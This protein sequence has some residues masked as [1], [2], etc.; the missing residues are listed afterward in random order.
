MTFQQRY[1]SHR[2]LVESWLSR[3]FS[4]RGFPFDGLLEAIEYS[5]LAGGKR[6]RPVLALEFCRVC[7]GDF[8]AALPIA[9][10]VELLHTYSLI[11]DD[12]PC[13]DDD[14]L[15]RG[16]PTNHKV[17]GECTAVLAGD[18][19]QAEA[20]ASIF[21][22]TLP[23]ERQAEC[24]RILAGAA[25][26][27]GICGGQHMDMSWEGRRLTEEELSD[28][29]SR[30]TGSLL[31]AACAMGAAAAGAC[32]HKLQAALAYGSALGAAFQIIDDVLDV[33]ASAGELGKTPGSDSRQ[34]KTTYMTLWGEKAC[35]ERA[36]RITEYAQKTV[37]EA[38]EE[39]GFLTEL[40]ERL[41]ERRF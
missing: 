12:L 17:Y 14:D 37:R 7:G 1:D 33:T 6:I 27:D 18:A 5:L 16:R 30:K 10:A 31:A 29:Q 41:L 36:A 24:A 25:G 2:E 4:M 40:A 20:F 32:E 22:S 21:N 39:A 9:G 28:L 35:R 3:R 38:F 34:G 8:E 13:M 15:R 11:H 26:L 23:A 19:L